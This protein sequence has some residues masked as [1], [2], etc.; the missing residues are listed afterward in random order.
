MKEVNFLRGLKSKYLASAYT[1]SIYFA[2]D[3]KEIIVNGVSYGSVDIDDELTEVGKN[4]VMGSAIY[5]AIKENIN[6]AIN[7]APYGAKLQVISA[8]TNVYQI[9]LLDKNDNELSRTSV[10]V[11]DQS[12]ASNISGIVFS[13]IGDQNI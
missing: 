8:G 7:T 2:T 13:R 3:T 12:G 5:K 10:I 6:D 1:D 9:L 4:P 11:G